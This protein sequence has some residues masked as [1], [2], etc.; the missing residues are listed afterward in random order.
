[1]GDR[2]GHTVVAKGHCPACGGTGIRGEIL[3]EEHVLVSADL[4]ARPYVEPRESFEAAH[5]RHVC[6]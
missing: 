6:S 4:E 1:M 3:S 2:E 5:H